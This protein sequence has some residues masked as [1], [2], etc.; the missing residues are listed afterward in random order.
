MIGHG[1]PASLALALARSA[2]VLC[3][4]L[5]GPTRAQNAPPSEPIQLRVTWGGGE[6]TRWLGRINV[7]D[8]SFSNLNILGADA[9]APGSV[10]IEGRQIRVA[11]LS[12]HKSD[13]LE[14]TLQAN[15]T[16]KLQ[17][18]LGPD[19]KTPQRVPAPHFEVSLADLAR[20]PYQVRLDERGNTLEIQIVA[21]PALQIASKRDPPIFA[22]G[23]TCSIE[24]AP[25]PASVTPGTQLVVHTTLTAAR[26]KESMWNDERRVE[27]PV[28]GQPKFA[29]DVPLPREEGVYTIHVAAARPSGF[30]ERFWAA[31]TRLAERSFQ[32]VVLEPN[33]PAPAG[34]AQWDGV[35]EIDPTNPRW[36]E[37]LPTWTQL[38]RIPGLSRAPLGNFRSVAADPRLGRFNELPRTSAGDPHWQAYSLPLEAVGIP[39]MLEV[40]YPAQLEHALGI[41]IVEP[42]ARGLIHGTH[43]DGG[44]YVEGLGRSE[45]T[46]K[47]TY[48]MVF[49]PRTQAPLLVVTNLN[50][51]Q[52]AFYGAIRVYKRSTNN[53]SDTK[54]GG[55]AKR[56][57]LIAAYFAQSTVG[58]TLGATQSIGTDAAGGTI[59][60][61]VEDPQ[62]AY[63]SA[64]RLA[65]YVRYA[66]YNCAIVNIGSGEQQKRPG[67]RSLDVDK[68]EL[69]G[70]VFDREG[71]SLLPAVEFAA[72]LPELEL[73][74]RAN[75]AQTSGLEWVGP[76][77]RSWLEAN[78]N[79]QGLAPYYNLLDPRV[80]QAML[81]RVRELI[82]RYG[83]HSSFAGVAIQLS[84]DGYAQLPPID[85]GLDDATI[86]RFE[87]DTKISLATTENDR[88]AARHALL[89][90]PH[91]GTWR[92]WRAAQVSDFYTQ[93][94]SLVRGST[95]RRLILTTEN[96][97]AH[98]LVSN[99][100]RPNLLA[101][102]A[103][104]RA[105]ATMSDV[106]L[107]REVLERV[108]GLI[109]CPTRYVA[110]MSPLP[111]RAHDFELNDAFALWHQAS[112]PL[113][114]RGALLYHRP[115]R[116][117]L[118]SFE[119]ARIP[120]RMDGEMQLTSQPLADVGFIRQPY[121]QAVADNE[122]SIII[123]GG[124]LLPLG[125]EDALR[126]TRYIVSQ[127]PTDAVVADASKQ[128][129]LVRSYSEPDRV[130][131]VAMNISP[132]HCDAQVMLD[133]PQPAALEPLVSSMN[134]DNPAAK[135]LPLAAGR[136]PWPITL[137]PYEMRA[138]R[139]PVPNTKVAEVQTK[140]GKT[141][142][143][144]LAQVLS[145]LSNRDLT[146]PSDY[147]KL[148][149]PNFEPLAAGGRLLGWHITGNNVKATAELDATAPQD[150]KTCL[151]FRCDGQTA[152]LESDPF[153]IPPTGQLAMTIYAR[154][155]N[156]GP[157]TKL[158]IAFETEHGGQPY[159]QFARVRPNTDWG[160]PFVVLLD[161][162][163]FESRGQMRVTFEL[164]G[165]GEV[166]LDNA[167]LDALLFPLKCYGNGQ[168]ELMQ[169]SQRIYAAES[170][171][172]AGQT[173][174][175]VRMFDGYW[176]R[177]VLAYRPP[178]QPKIATATRPT[179]QQPLPAQPNQ[180]QQPAP[181][182]GDGIK[183]FV[184]PFLR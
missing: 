88:F 28:S 102:S 167:K 47:Q 133:V 21:L 132:W 163:P 14:A 19:D 7:E 95:N 176:P 85:W 10:W 80:Q 52:P 89:T 143:D 147:E 26:R 166:W 15:T 5:V 122:P 20:H 83:G 71:L 57:R 76:D 84:S 160:A 154:A 152:Q 66:G 48:R 110:P 148:L 134:D 135:P 144:E 136:Q 98:P 30:T 111:D 146:A 172:K 39:H 138:V 73:L 165:P 140:L 130:T 18:E 3:A 25:A 90:G 158:Q 105:A 72:P 115:T 123:D 65:D 9:D 51:S 12:T 164:D 118:A 54:P 22:P 75:N 180:G 114:S 125:Q 126:E 101:E 2:L 11:A 119:K 40:D 55:A 36:L 56:D 86:A 107:D 64:T 6:P 124:E 53:L 27:V 153:P 113:S 58:T 116:Q 43:R 99:A 24:L 137:A 23:E 178:V 169:L 182:F 17:I 170:A 81:E 97:F 69:I 96:V 171:F 127:L 46:E 33:P 78:G 59:A 32:V 129:I 68:T 1:R 120:W 139:I 63:E 74:R 179:Q 108:P 151:Y 8:G 177:F 150:G 103:A 4:L 106:G 117:R 16:A 109:L 50:P 49:W 42:D 70:R 93:L 44:V 159:F 131:L 82:D 121:V 174:D 184:P 162:L 141:A 91:V 60:D 92:S 112:T 100:M 45:A 156:L 61:S 35:L 41:S 157:N 145:A 104:N 13:I 79:R 181:G 87:R 142:G 161:N 31:S 29:L 128:P 62:T 173:S 175:C 149:N 168:K 34:K 94:A 38:Q 183:R 37:R 67:A 155:Q 77:G